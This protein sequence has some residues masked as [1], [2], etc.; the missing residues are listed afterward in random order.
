MKGWDDTMKTI[1]GLTLKATS[2]DPFLLFWSILLPVGGTVGLGLFIKQ[3]GYPLR[4]MTGMMAVGV[5]F[6]AF[7]TTAFTILGQRSRGV[8]SLLRVTP[9]P[10]WQYISGVSGAWTLVSFL[11]A[12]LVFVAGKIVFQLDVSEL[13]ILLLLPVVLLAALGYVF[14]SFFV[15]SMCRTEA[16]VSMA[17]NVA[18]M[19]LLFCSDAF[20]ALDRA[21]VWLQT[22]TRFNPFQWFIDGL[23]NAFA[24][25][26]GGW[27]ISTGLLLTVLI[28]ALLL[29]VQTFKYT[30]V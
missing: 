3:V 26:V 18:S 25:N 27:L 12:M 20:Y 21:P 8:Y 14:L 16:H 9:M 11:C 7:T 6:Y 10:L 24:L 4:I 13:S 29:A 30:D 1:L 28:I 22:I 2:R 23:R 5:L 17:T 19:L 15:S